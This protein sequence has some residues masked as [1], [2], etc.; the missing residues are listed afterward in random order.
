MNIE[1]LLINKF[2][3]TKK[4]IEHLTVKKLDQELNKIEREQLLSD[5]YNNLQQTL[6]FMDIY[7]AVKHDNSEPTWVNAL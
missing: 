5:V 7:R 3:Q 2:F 4:D 1:N 6:R